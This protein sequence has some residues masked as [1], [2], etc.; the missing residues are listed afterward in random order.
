MARRCVRIGSAG[1]TFSL[2]G[3]KV[4]YVSGPTALIAPVAKAHQFTTF[5]T[6]PHLQHAVAHGLNMPDAYFQDLAA[7]LAAKRDRLAAGL[8]ALGLP[9]L[10]AD[11][12]YFLIADIEA[13]GRGDDVA[14]AQA[15]TV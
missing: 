14:V 6:P 15:M 8:N 9:T 11:C 4:G 3:W 1:K 5:T 13:L 10:Q 7:G 12:S 2:T